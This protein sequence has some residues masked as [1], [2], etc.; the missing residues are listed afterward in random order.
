MQDETLVKVV[1]KVEYRAL[2]LAR[3]YSF[4]QKT[5]AS[6]SFKH[7]NKKITAGLNVAGVFEGISAAL[8]IKIQHTIDKISVS[9]EYQDIQK[10]LVEE[11]QHGFQQIYRTI[12]LTVH[13]NGQAAENVEETY[14]DV[15]KTK[16]SAAFTPEKLNE[17]A[18][19]YIRDHLGVEIQP[20]Q[21]PTF[22]KT[23]C[24][25]GNSRVFLIRQPYY[26]LLNCFNQPIS[27]TL[28]QTLSYS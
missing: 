2:A 27:D 25:L 4:Q 19:E 8:G 7:E 10:G 23:F 28:S 12:T 20:D 24:T 5:T 13:V 1:V 16:D 17:M 9:R 21:A 18:R 6:T 11:F 14:V 26:P 22:T 15:V 3:H